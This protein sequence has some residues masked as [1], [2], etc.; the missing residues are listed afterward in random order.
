[1]LEQGTI[2]KNAKKWCN[3]RLWKEAIKQHIGAENF[4]AELYSILKTSLQWIEHNP[5]T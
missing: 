1:K 2:V 4:D 5:V 3:E